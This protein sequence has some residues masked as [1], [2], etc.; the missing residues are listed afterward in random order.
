MYTVNRRKQTNNTW[1]AI[2][3]DNKHNRSMHY[4]CQM[5]S[6]D[7]YGA[8]VSEKRRPQPATNVHPVHSVPFSCVT[9]NVRGVSGKTTIATPVLKKSDVEPH[10]LQFGLQSDFRVK[11]Y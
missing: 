5:S 7:K 9:C 3:K 10:Y 8:I 1:S 2:D 4:K 6:R 11:S